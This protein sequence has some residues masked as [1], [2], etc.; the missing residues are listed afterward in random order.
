MAKA[1]EV[2]LLSIADVDADL[3]GALGENGEAF[4]QAAKLFG[5]RSRLCGSATLSAWRPDQVWGS[6]NGAA[7]H[8][9]FGETQT[10]GEAEERGV[11]QSGFERKADSLCPQA[12]QAVE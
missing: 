8:D 4:E 11:G 9:L 2:S 3:A 1:S 5:S 10:E 12:A 7:Y 6:W